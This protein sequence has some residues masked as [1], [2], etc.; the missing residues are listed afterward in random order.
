M[1]YIRDAV[2]RLVL[3]FQNGVSCLQ[4]LC[5]QGVY[6]ILSQ[7][8]LIQH[9]L[10]VYIQGDRTNGVQ[11]TPCEQGECTVVLTANQSCGDF[12]CLCIV[13][14]ISVGTILHQFIIIGLVASCDVQF[15]SCPV[16]FV[17]DLGITV[18][19]TAL[20]LIQRSVHDVSG[21]AAFT[22]GVAAPACER[23]VVL[24]CC[25]IGLDCCVF[26][27]LCISCIIVL[28]Q[29][30]CLCKCCRC[31]QGCCIGNRLNDSHRSLVFLAVFVLVIRSDSQT[32]PL[33]VVSLVVN[34][35]VVT[36]HLEEEVQFDLA[37]I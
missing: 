16:E 28:E 33:I 37:L 25:S 30:S 6:F 13:S 23:L 15:A 36:Y 18:R 1:T 9:I 29:T 8:T 5:L 20:V 22:L 17:A 32:G 31:V 21:D 14:T 7:Q 11:S 3:Y 27:G 35:T 2:C 10:R 24:L 26:H 12:Q 4:N 34:H 19:A